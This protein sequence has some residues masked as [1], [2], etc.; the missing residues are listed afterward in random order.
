MEQTQY[1]RACNKISSQGEGPESTVQY[2]PMPEEDT[3]VSVRV[4]RP[5]REREERR[6][7]ERDRESRIKQAE[8]LTSLQGTCTSALHWAFDSAGA[9]KCWPSPAALQWD[10]TAVAGVPTPPPTRPLHTV[11]APIPRVGLWIADGSV[12]CRAFPLFLLFLLVMRADKTETHHV[13][14]LHRGLCCVV[15]S[16][17]C[18]GPHCA[19][20]TPRI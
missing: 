19:S 10:P 4:P 14:G 17:W 16:H 8:E 18:Q 5:W 6:E 13:G 2:G 15:P 11:L 7:M 1:P 9:P 20:A 3:A 12:S